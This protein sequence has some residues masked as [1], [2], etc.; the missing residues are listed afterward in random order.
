MSRAKIPR[1]KKKNPTPG[2]DKTDKF[3]LISFINGWIFFVS[4]SFTGSP[5]SPLF[6][7]VPYYVVIDCILHAPNGK[8]HDGTHYPTILS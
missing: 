2:P 4:L 6:T 1:G 8:Q 5:V 3:I 7:N